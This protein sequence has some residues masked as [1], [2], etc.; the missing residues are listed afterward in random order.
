MA[1]DRWTVE[2]SRA[3]YHPRNGR[4]VWCSKLVEVTPHVLIKLLSW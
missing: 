3:V 1:H 2:P 4:S